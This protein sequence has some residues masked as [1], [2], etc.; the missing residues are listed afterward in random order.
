MLAYIETE[1]RLIRPLNYARAA[2]GRGA[3]FFDAPGGRRVFVAQVLG[4]AFMKRPFDDPFSALD[5][6]LKPATLGGEPSAVIVEVHAEATS[7]K[8]ALGHWCD[9]RASLV[10]GTHTHVPTADLQIL[11]RGAAYQSDAGMCGDYDS[12]IGMDKLEPITRFVT[13]MPKGRF[14]PAEGEA[15]LC[16]VYVETDDATGRAREAV[17]VRIGGRLGQSSP[18]GPHV[19]RRPSGPGVRRMQ[20]MLPAL[21]LLGAGAAWGLTLPLMRVAVS[22]GYR[23]LALIVWQNLIMAAVLAMVLAVMRLPRPAVRRRRGRRRGGRGLRVG[24]AGLLRLPDRRAAAG[25]GAVD[26]HRAGADVRAADGA[27]PRLRAAGGAPGAGGAARGGGDR[28]DRRSGRPGGGGA[29]GLVPVLLTMIAPLSYAV[30]ANWLAA[31]GS[32]GLHPF[33]LLLGASLV[34]TALAW[35]LAEVTGQMVY[36]TTWGA[37]EAAAVGLSLLN[38]LAYSAYVWLVGAAGSVYREPGRLS[39]HR[40]RRG[41]VDGPARGALLG[42]IWGALALMLLG[43]ALIQPRRRPAKEA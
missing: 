40:L 28:A 9:G 19:E 35:P 42:M 34:S 33:Q 1:P 24:A 38:V 22:T 36:P 25:G 16:G 6:A 27:G 17:P 14:A 8:M 20:R 10:V 31:R 23:P 11:A 12:V 4:Q 29:V 30:E 26:H 43:V 2:P 21:V 13:G 5:A 41:L 37:A 15:T 7:E 3:R 39:R 32:H 18:Q